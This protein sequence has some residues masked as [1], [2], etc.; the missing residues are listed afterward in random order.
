MDCN[1]S[2]GFLCVVLVILNKNSTVEN[3]CT[4]GFDLKYLLSGKLYLLGVNEKWLSEWK[5]CLHFT[6]P[7]RHSDADK[8]FCN[9]LVMT[10]EWF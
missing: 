8:C 10:V 4:T 1:I 2:V 3:K 5:V 7:P 6:H 9:A